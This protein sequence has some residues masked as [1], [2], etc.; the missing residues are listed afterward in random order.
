MK[1][2]HL[3]LKAEYFDQIASGTKHFEYR[4]R[5]PYWTKRLVGKHFDQVHIKKGYPSASDATRVLIRP[6]RGLELQTIAHPHFG[7]DPVEV[8]A[9]R[10]SG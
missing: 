4:L 6:W 8:Y 3:N 5:T 2:L 1:V 9:I 7:P 10:V